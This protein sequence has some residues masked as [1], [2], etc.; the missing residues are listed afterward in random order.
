MSESLQQIVDVASPEPPLVRMT[1][2]GGNIICIIDAL[3]FCIF[4]DDLMLEKKS[5]QAFYESIRDWVKNNNWESQTP[6]TLI[7]PADGVA[8]IKTARRAFKE[9]EKKFDASGDSQQ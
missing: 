9:W 8:L 5:A 4:V 3:D 1:G 6:P 7:G 2:K